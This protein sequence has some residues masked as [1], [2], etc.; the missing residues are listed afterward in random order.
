MEMEERKRSGK[1][2]TRQKRKCWDEIRKESL[3]GIVNQMREKEK[4]QRV[5]VWG[6]KRKGTVSERGMKG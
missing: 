4:P 6:R 1:R 2:A 3:D 5:K